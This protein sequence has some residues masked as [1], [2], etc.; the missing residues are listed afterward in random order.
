MAVYFAFWESTDQLGLPVIEG[1]EVAKL[2]PEGN[3]V[4]LKGQDTNARLLPPDMILS[5]EDATDLLDQLRFL[6]EE[7]TRQINCANT[8]AMKNMRR[9]I[10]KH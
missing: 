9:A 1:G 4:L 2:I 3:G 5:K 10:D 8:Q 6:R 7:R